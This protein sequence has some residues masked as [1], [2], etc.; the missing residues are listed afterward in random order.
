MA[1]SSYLDQLFTNG[2]C[3]SIQQGILEIIHLQGVKWYEIV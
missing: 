3:I 1:T 2:A